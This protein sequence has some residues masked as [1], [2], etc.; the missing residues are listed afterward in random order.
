MGL[1]RAQIARGSSIR[2]IDVET[3]VVLAAEDVYGELPS[4]LSARS[5]R[6][7][8]GNSGSGFRCSKE[9]RQG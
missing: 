8:L 9:V 7:W 4:K 6:G 3:T 2:L 1:R 5:W